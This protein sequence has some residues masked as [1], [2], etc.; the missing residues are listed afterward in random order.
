MTPVSKPI[1]P[2]KAGKQL[3]DQFATP[4]LESWS[5]ARCSTWVAETEMLPQP[6]VLCLGAQEPSHSL[7]PRCFGG[8]WSQPGACCSRVAGGQLAML[9]RLPSWLWDSKNGTSLWSVGT[10]KEE[11]LIKSCP[12]HMGP[13]E[14]RPLGKPFLVPNLTV[15]A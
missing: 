9:Y 14:M 3:S 13:G 7:H 11:N 4:T 8:T 5:C 10:T 12:S 2:R 1:D 15:S 6:H